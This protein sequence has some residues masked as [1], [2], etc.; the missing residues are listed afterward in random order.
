M[1]KPSLPI[2]ENGERKLFCPVP[3]QRLCYKPQGT[4]ALCCE[5]WLPTMIGSYRNS[6]GDVF[7]SEIAQRIRA[8]ILDGSFSYCNLD[9]C[10]RYQ[11]NTLPFQDE[12]RDP[13][14]RK[15]IDEQLLT[16]PDGPSLVSLN[17]DKSCNLSCPSCRTQKIEY[18]SGSQFE[19][20]RSTHKRLIDQLLS[21]RRGKPL[22]LNINGSGDPFASRVLREFLFM[23][24]GRQ[25]PNVKIQLMTNGLMLTEKYW[26]RM[27]R[28]HQNISNIAISFDAANK[29]TY[30]VVRRGGDWEQ[31]LR[32]TIFLSEQ[33]AAGNLTRLEL[34]FIV[35]LLNFRE[36]PQ[37]VAMG[38]LLPR[39]DAVR[40]E[41][42]LDW[43]TWPKDEYE[44]HAVWRREHPLFQRLLDVLSDPILGKSTVKLM[45]LTPLRTEAIARP[46][47]SQNFFEKQCL[48]LL[49]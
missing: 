33:R 35:Q 23:F 9:I 48:Q 41:K 12:V 6:R 28:I 38:D 37:L 3:F 11:S 22:L 31:L 30:S 7:N 49:G 2:V 45:N 19:I 47:G 13:E 46:S 16:V 43:K 40:F 15:I 18:K 34:H 24:D 36:I 42:L 4:A 17:Y 10:G 21:T 39:I 44:H 5:T 8:S 20:V 32:N 26:N 27:Y 29:R 14:L 1:T 25:H